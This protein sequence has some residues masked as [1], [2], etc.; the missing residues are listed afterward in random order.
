M[1]PDGNAKQSNNGSVNAGNKLK[2]S[3]EFNSISNLTKEKPSESNAI[4]I[5]QI[6]LPRGGGAL[7][8]IDE[9]FEINAANGTASF[10]VPLPLSPGRN[11][12]SPSLALSYNSGSGNSPYGLGWSVDYPMI[13]RKTDKRLPRYQGDREED[14]F[15]FSGAEDLVPYLDKDGDQWLRR[16]Q[17]TED[18][19]IHQYRPRIE[20]GFTRIE[21]I[22]RKDTAE[23]YWKVTT[24][25]NT[26]TF[27]GLSQEAQLS[28][29]ENPAKIFAWLPSFS[30]DDK[31]NWIIYEYKAEDLANVP[32]E[33]HEK[34]RLNGP[35]RFTN[36][37]LKRAKYCNRI[38]W[39][40]DHPYIP[41]LP[42]ENAE[43]FFELVMDYGE[44]NDPE[45]DDQPPDYQEVRP[46]EARPD[47]FSS[48]R[49]GFEIRTYRRCF[50]I[51]MFHHFPDEQQW[52][53]SIFGRNYLVRLLSL[54]FQS[55]S[56]N[57]S[58]QTEVSYLQSI[59][60]KGYI[61]QA[62]NTYSVKQ[63]PPMEFEYQ[64]LLWN[65]EV[66]LVDREN[67]AN[68]PVGLTGNYQWVDLYGEGINGI[69]TE[70][71]KGWFYKSNL[72]DVD[73]DQQVSFTPALHVIPKPSL[74]G[75]SSGVLSLQDLESNG[76]K[77]V[78]V[79]SPGLQGY[80]ELTPS[81]DYKPFQSFER[82]ANVG[83]QDP[84]TRLLD[85][86]GDGQP[87]L[88]MTEENLFVWYSP[89]G[90]KG[91]SEAEYAVKVLD[92]EHGPALVFASRDQQESIFLADMT[93]DGLTDI[94]RVRNGEICYWANTGYGQF[95]AKVTMSNAPVFDDPTLF[96]PQYLQLADISGTGA[97][98]IIYLGKNK[99]NAFINLSGNA[100]SQA[101]EIDP[102]FPIDSNSQISVIDLL[103]T[104]TSS[105]VWSSDLPEES[106]APM[107][108]IDLMDSKKP[109]VLKK[110][111][112]NFGKETTLEYKSSTYFYLKD[113]L[114]GTPWITKLPF[115]TQVVARSIV[116]DK[117]TRVRFA[118]EYRYHH[119]YYDHPEREF[120]GFG[121]V[122]QL[123]TEAYE[124]WQVNNAGNQL[125]KSEA[126][127]QAPTLVKT[128]FHTGAFLDRN[129]ILS[130]F[131]EEYWYERYNRYFPDASIAIEEPELQDA[132]I[133]ANQT[134][135]D[136]FNIHNLNA[137]EYREALRA[138][139]G[140]VL[141]QEVFSL[142]APLEDA[143]EED[144]QKQCKPYTVA[145]HNC[146]IQ[147]L[148]PKADNNHAVFIVT[149]SEAI[150]I[151]MNVMK[152]IRASRT[153]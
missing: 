145:T 12:F 143:S 8:G 61:R 25:D 62:D 138:C 147:L 44:H 70:Q 15:M 7:K 119:G 100:W 120:R 136:D 28:D 69:L 47:A 131:R 101:H 112:N 104:G 77:Q 151:S 1:Q 125:E 59:V 33:L 149:E 9:K 6:S 55:S 41:N 82:I 58:G 11:G 24:P 103:G 2:Q 140:M 97:T 95:S 37:Y 108:Y 56:I 40:S 153:R 50:N 110:Y 63:L 39:Y 66:R 21:R 26:T 137:E 122:E 124:T 43:Y 123:D 22:T 106:H 141:R 42:E 71:A 93:G 118:S 107:R 53:G 29:P 76:Q 152:P 135:A 72:G 127:Y 102:F 144:R 67:I 65:T 87:E 116:E 64:Q 38:P 20:G 17:E 98:D 115:P 105:I 45:E 75:L 34:N 139:K 27:F 48:Y 54:N 4:Q 96:N 80:Y 150:T 16:E 83:L 51:L 5:P 60:Q 79:N 133:V 129:R 146:H 23:I 88:V 134:I 84:N 94:V 32:N 99:F 57:E 13:Q 30:F 128:W 132:R 148:Q 19:I 49:S 92:E 90:K 68:A 10:S 86:N 114:D 117:I 46:W 3:E 36:R 73:E 113:K 121:M 91:Y 52:D 78:V 109:H 126:L 35:A 74:S 111:V 14:T 18:V 142:D 85:L 89:E 31:G 130:H 81:N